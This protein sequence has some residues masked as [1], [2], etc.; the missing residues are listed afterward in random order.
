MTKRLL[1]TSPAKMEEK[2]L[3]KKFILKTNLLNY[4]EI[5]KWSRSNSIIENF[6]GKLIPT[7]LL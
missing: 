6:N 1:S 2:V 5:E 3:S 4:K 7:T